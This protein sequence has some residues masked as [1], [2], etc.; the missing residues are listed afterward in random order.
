MLAPAHFY[1]Y[2]LP[3]DEQS[4]TRC[5]WTHQDWCTRLEDTFGPGV[6]TVWQLAR[7]DNKIETLDHDDSK[8]DKIFR[9]VHMSQKWALNLVNFLLGKGHHIPISAK[10]LW[11]GVQWSLELI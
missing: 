6:L 5:N 10:D 2:E 8:F 1:W 7:D 3:E 4:R 11:D 9:F